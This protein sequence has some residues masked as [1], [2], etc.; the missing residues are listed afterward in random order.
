MT[1][2]YSPPGAAGPVMILAPRARTICRVRPKA[3][4]RRALEERGAKS[5]EMCRVKGVKRKSVKTRTRV[6][7]VENRRK[8]MI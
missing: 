8:S 2:T 3:K 6:K 1:V 5:F 4:G 7:G